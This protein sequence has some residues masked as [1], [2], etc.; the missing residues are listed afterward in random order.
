M[1]EG[2]DLGY[3]V[4]LAGSVAGAL[5]VGA[6]LPQAWR[7]YRRRSAVDVSLTMY[8]TIIFSSLL[9]MFYAHA[10]NSVE[11]FVTNLIILVIAV[12]I[13]ILRIRFGDRS[14]S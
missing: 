5:S 3:M 8:V 13:A 12:L 9:W 4:A 1:Q 7:I 11:L 2:A 10:R 6:F 14:M